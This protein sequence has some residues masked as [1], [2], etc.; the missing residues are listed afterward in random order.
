MESWEKLQKPRPLGVVYG[1]A[2]AQSGRVIEED[3]VKP[4][5]ARY[6]K[7]TAVIMNTSGHRNNNSKSMRNSLETRRRFKN[8]TAVCFSSSEGGCGHNIRAL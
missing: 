1:I 7:R 8:K 5:L 3:A 6:K 2:A 4:A